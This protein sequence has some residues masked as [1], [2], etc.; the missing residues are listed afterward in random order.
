MQIPA[1]SC[2]RLRKLLYGLKQAPRVWSSK[3]HS[4]MVELNFTQ[5]KSDPCLYTNRGDHIFLVVYVD[6]G[7]IIADS[8]EKCG[9]VVAG[10][11][12]SK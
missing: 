7:I 6:D 4:T 12:K 9:R 2:L 11:N 10:T 5:A 1:D 8:T 3:F